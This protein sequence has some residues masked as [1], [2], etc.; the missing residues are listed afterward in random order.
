MAHLEFREVSF[1][2]SDGFALEGIN[3]AVAQGERVALV[4][5]N[6]SGKTT[7]LRLASGLLRPARGQVL[8]E[9]IDLRSLPRREVARQM[10]LVPQHFH[11]PFAFQVSEVVEMGRAPFQGALSVGSSN[12]KAVSQA[13]SVTG[14]AHLAGRLFNELSGGERQRVILAL[15]LAQQPRLLLMDEPTAHLDIH[16]QHEILT[17]V[18]ELNQKQGITVLVAIHDL[19]LAAQYCERLMLLHQGRIYAQGKPEQVLTVSNL[20]AA[21]GA[22]FLIYPHP[23]TGSPLVLPLP[24]DGGG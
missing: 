10:A 16:H 2:Y 11:L 9:G 17:M 15:A 21:Y 19:N 5:A 13:L 20:Q 24:E 22:P 8:L 6:A 18:R 4:G 12:G 3:L 23:V 7:L 14:T 1:S